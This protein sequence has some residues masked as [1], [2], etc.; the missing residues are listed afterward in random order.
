VGSTFGFI[1]SDLSDNGVVKSG[2]IVNVGVGSVLGPA[3][4][5]ATTCNGSTADAIPT[6]FA[7]VHPAT[8]GSTGLR[9]FGTD[10]RGTIFV[11]NTGAIFTAASVASSTTPL[12]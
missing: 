6:Y 5:A 9:S 4:P 1:S 8:P 11:D 10:Q 3:T 2:Y 12:Q 7:E